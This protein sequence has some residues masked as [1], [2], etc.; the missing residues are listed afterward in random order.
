MKTVITVLMVLMSVFAFAQKPMVG[1]SPN[2]IKQQNYIEFGTSYSSW[3]VDQ[4]KGFYMLSTAVE[5]VDGYA[6]YYFTDGAEL[7][8][9]YAL[10]MFDYKTYSYLRTQ[11]LKGCVFQSGGWYKQTESGLYV[12]FD[13]GVSDGKAMYMVIYSP[14]MYRKD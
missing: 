13:S 4:G 3:S 7:N 11:T 6:Y 5:S 12:Y 1:F 14:E 8:Y 9:R 2:N 10:I